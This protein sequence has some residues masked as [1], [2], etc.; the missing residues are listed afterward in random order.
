MRIRWKLLLLLL[1]IALV[2]L[3]IALWFGRGEAI[4]AADQLTENTRSLLISDAEQFLLQTV[5]DNG[6]L[7]QSRAEY[8]EQ[9]VR[10][11]ARAAAEFLEEAPPID[12]QIRFM[13]DEPNRLGP[14]VATRPGA[15]ESGFDFLAFYLAP[16]VSREAV[17]GDLARLTRMLQTYQLARQSQSDNLLWQ[18][19]STPSGIHSFYPGDGWLPENYD[20]RQRPWFQEAVKA[21]K[22][23]WSP[24]LKDAG[25]QEVVLTIAMP[26]YGR[27][28]ELRAVTAIDVRMSQTV[29][30]VDLPAHW[31]QHAETMIVFPDPAADSGRGAI[32]VWAKQEYRSDTTWEVPLEYET[33]PTTD[34][35]RFR[36]VLEDLR[37]GRA[38]VRGVRYRGRET[39]WAYGPLTGTQ[40]SLLVILPHDVVLARALD[41]DVQIHGLIEAQKNWIVRLLLAVI[42]V[43]VILAITASRYITR[44]IRELAD[45]AHRIAIGDLDTPVRVRTRDELGELGGVVNAM[46]PQLRDRLRMR[47]G[48]SV[49]MAVQKSLLPGQLPEIKGWDVAGVCLFSDETGGDY[50][51]F[52]DLSGDHPGRF[53]AAVGDVTGHGIGAA[54]MMATVRALL[55]SGVRETDSLGDLIVR[56]NQ[57]LLRPDSASLQ[58][59]TLCCLVFD[60]ESR[61]VRWCSAGHDA[62]LLYDPVS[63]QFSE[64]SSGGGV[65]LGL[66][67][68]WHYEELGPQAM[69][70][71]QLVV[72][73]TDGIWEA[74]NA[75]GDFF[76]KERLKAAVAES[77]GR[78]AGAIC[79]AVTAAVAAFRGERRQEDDLTLVIVKLRA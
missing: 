5:R 35:P 51:D 10:F 53:A 39:I 43:I 7:L 31:R 16:G 22:L 79:A 17:A 32:R 3:A 77:A 28:G 14:G 27:G 67:A 4:R 45:A 50:Y 71:D 66:Q 33:L 26:V 9:N 11:Q 30:V 19:T 38:G 68:D 20:P 78:G 18:F 42:A 29:S 63:Q 12:P 36:P 24:P 40:S 72:I 37:A 23:T 74:R 15:G 69:Q 62:P 75:A 73:G 6:R 49:A 2:P 54:L 8:L 34:D 55:R 25:T 76:G 44:P 59:M 57:E 13:R 64:L 70:P 58:L 21:G 65:P 41:A 60:A 56:I 52:V 61:S 48:L 47:E 46:L 1:A